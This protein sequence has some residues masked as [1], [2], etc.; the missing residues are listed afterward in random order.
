MT[1]DYD[2]LVCDNASLNAIPEQNPK[3]HR[4][5]LFYPLFQEMTIS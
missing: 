5:F 2:E 4:A 3:Q 1:L